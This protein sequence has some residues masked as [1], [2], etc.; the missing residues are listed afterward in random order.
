MRHALTTQGYGIRLRP[1]RLDDAPFI[2]WLR[3]LDYVKGRV[4]DSA[5]DVTVQERWLNSYFEREGDYYFIVETLNETPLGT[6][7]I[8]N[9][10]GNSAEIGRNIIRPGV[11]AAIP[12]LILLV[13]LIYGQMGMTQV[14]ATA[15][16]DS[17]NVHSLFRKAGFR[18]VGVEHAGLVIGGEAI[19]MVHFV[20][21]AEDW[22]RVRERGNAPARRAEL[23]IGSWEQN[24]LQ[25]CAQGLATET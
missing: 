15:V 16:A 5:A 6:E 3:N 19:D 14:R 7:G 20:Q 2:V 10:N 4:G 1:V 8:Y 21:N 23:M 24:Y 18:Q 22:W 25:S 9:L 12:T 17:R 13:D 11:P